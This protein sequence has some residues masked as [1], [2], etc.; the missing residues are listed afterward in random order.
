MIKDLLA[1]MPKEVN[2]DDLKL[3]SFEKD[4]DL[5]SSSIE[6]HLKKIQGIESIL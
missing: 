3:G 6:G 2:L 1:R 4:S 5:L